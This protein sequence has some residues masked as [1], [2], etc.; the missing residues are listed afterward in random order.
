M[1]A[2]C[3]RWRVLG[4]GGVAAPRTFRLRVRAR[5]SRRLTGNQ[6]CLSVRCLF[7]GL[8]ARIRLE[9]EEQDAEEMA[10]GGGSAARR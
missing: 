3:V 1:W 9:V 10:I 7:V 6:L 5:A 4:V 8:E 2:A